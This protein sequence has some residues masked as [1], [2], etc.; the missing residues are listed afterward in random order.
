MGKLSAETK[1]KLPW[2][3]LLLPLESPHPSLAMSTSQFRKWQQVA[4]LS[5]KKWVSLCGGRDEFMEGLKF[6]L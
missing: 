3:F 2:A 1:V 5:T 6:A 4:V